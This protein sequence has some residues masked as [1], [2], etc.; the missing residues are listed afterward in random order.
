MEK[1]KNGRNDGMSSPRLVYKRQGVLA[2]P[3]ELP[4]SGEVWSSAALWDCPRGEELKPPF[5]DF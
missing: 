4:A 3:S 5:R 1:Q 2:A